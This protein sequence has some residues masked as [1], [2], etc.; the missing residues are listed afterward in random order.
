MTNG[1]GTDAITMTEAIAAM[2][3]SLLD[4][5]ENAVS[6]LPWVLT[7]NYPVAL[8]GDAPE[9]RVT[10]AEASRTLQRYVTNVI[11]DG[12]TAC[13][14]FAKTPSLNGIRHILDETYT[15]G[16]GKHTG[17]TVGT[18]AYALNRIGIGERRVARNAKKAAALV[19]AQA[20]G[21]V[22]FALDVVF[23]GGDNKG[24]SRPFP[25]EF[26]ARKAWAREHISTADSLWYQDAKGKDLSKEA[27]GVILA[28]AHVS[29]GTFVVVDEDTTVQADDIVMTQDEAIITAAQ[30][31]G[32]KATTVA[33]ARNYLANL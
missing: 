15:I 10:K 19:T 25:N 22:W 28:K 14:Q 29:Q 30:A 27:K 5:A 33:G 11:E 7:G 16:S 20:A 24:E 8:K 23:S 18:F 3:L 13:S 26:Q 31:C 17:I 21:G 6:T 32:S 9:T 2:L 1:T 12:F 4:I